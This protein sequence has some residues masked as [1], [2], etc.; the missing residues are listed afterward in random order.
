[1]TFQAGG[2][3]RL[4][5]TCIEINAAGTASSAGQADVEVVAAVQG[6][7]TIQAPAWATAGTGG[8]TASVA[9]PGAGLTYNWT[10]QGGTFDGGASTAQGPQVNFQA[11]AGPALSLTCTASGP[12]AVSTPATAGVGIA[13][14]P[15]MPV[16]HSVESATTGTDQ[17][18]WV[19]AAPGAVYL[20]EITGGA[21]NG[22]D[23]NPV[24]PVVS[25]SAAAAGP[26]VLTCHALN[27]AGTLSD[28]GA[29]QVLFHLP[30]NQPALQVSAPSLFAGAAGQ[31]SVAN[32]NPALTYNWTIDGGTLTSPAQGPAVT[33]TAGAGPGVTLACTATSPAGSVSAPASVGVAVIPA[34]APPATMPRPRPRPVRARWRC[35]AGI[36]ARPTSGP[37]P[38][39]PSMTAPRWPT[40]PW[41]ATPWGPGR[42]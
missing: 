3:G 20:W 24:G 29:T 13:D 37:S 23:P 39:A 32:A 1:M 11:G 6:Q 31:A 18:A 41:W 34:A 5:L 33:F 35:A 12:G 16:V 40:P 15:Q 36:P 8:Y 42:R 38:A 9:Q 2:V 30:A 26:V 22:P 27:N 25:F 28:P 4:H 10:I 19:Q 21:F 17:F 14:A 7:P